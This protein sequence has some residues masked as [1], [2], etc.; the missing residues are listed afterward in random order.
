MQYTWDKYRSICSP[1]KCTLETTA[2]DYF[3]TSNGAVYDA[4][5]AAYIILR[6][7]GYIC[8]YEFH[9]YPVPSFCLLPSVYL[10]VCFVH[11]SVCASVQLEI[12]SPENTNKITDVRAFTCTIFHFKFIFHCFFTVVVMFV[13]NVPTTAMVIW[14]RDHGL[15]SHQTDW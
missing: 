7:M 10:S 11:V 4:I 13:F 15:K 12:H 5:K 2:D 8:I 1:I 9:A 3:V 14:R 6:I